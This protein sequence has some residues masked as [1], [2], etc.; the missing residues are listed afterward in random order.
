MRREVRRI[1]WIGKPVNWAAGCAA[2]PRYAVS[3][4][5]LSL[6]RAL[7]GVAALCPPPALSRAGCGPGQRVA[8]CVVRAHGL[9]RMCAVAAHCFVCMG[10]CGLASAGFGLM[11][12]GAVCLA[13]SYPTP[14]IYAYLFKFPNFFG[15]KF[16]KN[17]P[18]V[19]IL[20]IIP[21][22]AVKNFKSVPSRH[23]L[24]LPYATSIK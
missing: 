23:H 10:G 11:R 18:I 2:M 5:S 13:R 9:K 4:G 8:L 17:I 21:L 22:T 19:H 1:I 14:Q 16:Q 7:A 3:G 6:H 12:G 20:P 24:R 15:K